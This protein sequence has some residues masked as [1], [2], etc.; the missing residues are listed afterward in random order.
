ME[1]ADDFKNTAYESGEILEK[2]VDFMRQPTGIFCT[3]E[4]GAEKS[5]TATVDYRFEQ[6]RFSPWYRF[7]FY[8]YCQDDKSEQSHARHQ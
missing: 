2:T 7:G 1:M 5:L 4:V 3:R 8:S 6:G